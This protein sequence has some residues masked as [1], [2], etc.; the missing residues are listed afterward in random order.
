MDPYTAMFLA[1][2]AISV[3]GTVMGNKASSKQEK[4]NQIYYQRQA[5]FAKL[6]EFRQRQLAE[7][8][9]TNKIGQQISA[10]ASGGVALE[11][12][13][14]ITVGGTVKQFIDEAFAIK[15]KGDMEFELASTRARQSG[16]RSAMLDSAGYNMLQVGTSLMNSGATY[17]R[18]SG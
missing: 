4:Q 3:T 14:A 8:E 13:A 9:Y 12:S 7:F 1:S 10:Y 11:G 15:Q 2:A 16:A 18:A 6:A 5:E 17:A